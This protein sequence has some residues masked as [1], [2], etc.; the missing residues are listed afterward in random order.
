MAQGTVLRVHL[1]GTML[2]ERGDVVIR[3][4]AFPGRQGRLAFAMLA[5]DRGRAI[6][7]A[8]LADELWSGEPPDAWETALRAIMSKLRALLAEAGVMG[9]P[10]PSAAGC[11]RLRLPAG[12]WIDLE[13][14][15]DAVHRAEAALR[16]G[17]S[18]EATGWALV[19]NAIARRPFLP[20]DDG[21]FAERWR[22]R[23][24]EIRIRSLDV[25]ARTLLDRGEFGLAARDLETALELA[26]FRE[27]SYRL[28]MRAHAAAGNPAEGLRVYERCRALFSRELG[29]DP[30]R[31]TEQVYL[32]I[33]RSM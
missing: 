30:S 16:A 12:V 33:L 4:D 11:Y 23:L 31:E 14:A 19:G 22:A 13:A 9:D 2:L 15:D 5:A 29:V 21:R 27:T 20:G 1:A 10:I 17:D 32:E 28:L 18:E 26:P 25:R 24:N 8:E 3:E 6:N 7:R